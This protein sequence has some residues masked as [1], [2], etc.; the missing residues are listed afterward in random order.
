[1]RYLLDKLLS[2]VSRLLYGGV[3]PDSTNRRM[4]AVLPDQRPK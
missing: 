2:F 1:M 3:D 4:A